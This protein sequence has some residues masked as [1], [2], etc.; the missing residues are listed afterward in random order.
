LK[1]HGVSEFG[2]TEVHTVEP[3]VH[4]PSSLEIKFAIEKLKIY[5]SP[6]ID[7]NLAEIIQEGG[8]H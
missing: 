8:I 3:L 6:R 2:Q 7:Q 1:A 5:T 4:E